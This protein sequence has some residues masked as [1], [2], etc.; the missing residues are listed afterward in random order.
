MSHDYE[1]IVTDKQIS[2]IKKLEVR[3]NQ[4]NVTSKNDYLLDDPIFKSLK[5]VFEEALNIYLKE[6]LQ[7]DPK[8]EIYITQSWANFTG[9]NQYHHIHFHP[10]SFLSG[11]FY[12]DADEEVD[13]I[14][15]D[16]PNEGQYIIKLYPKN[17]NTFNSQSW[18]FPV[19]TGRLFLFPSTLKHRV[20]TKNEDNIRIS[21]SFNTFLKGVF[22]SENDLDRLIL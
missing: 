22:G 14:Y 17:Y 6:I 10:N 8:V 1:A 19:K 2:T 16:S 13:K 20:S 4:G 15:F 9:K 21:V 11:V 12:I 18:S 7:V 5:T 3:P